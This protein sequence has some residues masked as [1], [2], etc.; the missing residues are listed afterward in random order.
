MWYEMVKRGK[1]AEEGRT[2]GELEVMVGVGPLLGLLLD[3]LQAVKVTVA[4]TM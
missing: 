4:R 3:R 1:E 2:V